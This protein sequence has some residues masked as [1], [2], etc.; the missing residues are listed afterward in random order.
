MTKQTYQNML[1]AKVCPACGG[2]LIK[3]QC[4]QRGACGRNWDEPIAFCS[5]DLV[6]FLDPTGALQ[7]NYLLFID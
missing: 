5:P 3:N 1:K 6:S 7:A 4:V 2:L